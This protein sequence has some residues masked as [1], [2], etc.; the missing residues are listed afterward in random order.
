M[1]RISFPHEKWASLDDDNKLFDLN[2]PTHKHHHSHHSCTQFQLVLNWKCK[3][4][5]GYRNEC[6]LYIGEHQYLRSI[7]S[8]FA[9]KLGS[10]LSIVWINAGAT[11][12]CI[13]VKGELKSTRS[14]EDRT[15]GDGIGGG[16]SITTS[17]LGFSGSI[18]FSFE[19]FDS[20]HPGVFKNSVKSTLFFLQHDHPLYASWKYGMPG[21]YRQESEYSSFIILLI[22]EI[23]ENELK[24]QSQH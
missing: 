4:K 10:I 3:L 21:W 17:C 12:G 9:C 14:K 19:C 5:I 15:T 18:G 11:V 22:Q 1:T 2:R 20:S 6:I 24:C 23:Q 16:S 13:S 8:L 7:A